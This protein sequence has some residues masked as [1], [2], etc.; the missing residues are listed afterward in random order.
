MKVQNPI[1]GRARGSAGGMTFCKNYDKN[2]ARAKAFEVSNPNTP[3]QQNQ[4]TFFKEV[5]ELTAMFSEEEMRTLYP[6]KPKAMSRRNALSKQLAEDNK[7]VEGQ[8]VVD[9]ENI[10]TLGNASTLDFGTTTC[11]YSGQNIAVGLDAVVKGNTV[12]E[13]NN[14]FAAIV[15]DTKGEIYMAPE[16]GV[17]GTGTLTIAKPSNWETTDTI[18]AIPFILDSKSAGMQTVSFGTL[19]VTKRPARGGRNPHTGH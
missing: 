7:V 16:A 13:A 14:F 4:R 9:Y 18:H 12:F 2:V 11:A 5:S 1:I 6:Q 19:A 15:N 3:A 10:D 17:V 8:K